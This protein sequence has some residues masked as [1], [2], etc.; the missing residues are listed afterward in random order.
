MIDMFLSW[1]LAAGL[2]GLTAVLS[3]C[4]LASRSDCAELARTPGDAMAPARL[5][6]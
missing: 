5:E 3:S 4:V 2:F 6:K 1:F